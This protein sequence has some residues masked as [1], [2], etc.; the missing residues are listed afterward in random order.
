MYILDESWEMFVMVY[1]FDVFIIDL[2][3]V[4]CLWVNWIGCD[5]GVK[6]YILF[7]LYGSILVFV[8]VMVGEWYDMV[9]FIE[10]LIEFGSY[11]LMDCGY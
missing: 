4:L 3:L 1:V 10:L 11:Y 6:L 5:V 7:D 8:W 2:S 9:I